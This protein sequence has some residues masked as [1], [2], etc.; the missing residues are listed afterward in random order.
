MGKRQTRPA[1]FDALE[2]ANENHILGPGIFGLVGFG[3]MI[4]DM[5]TTENL[6]ACFGIDEIIQ[7][8]Q[9]TAI[10]YRTWNHIP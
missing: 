6:S 8:D 9:Q 7:G 5:S 1:T 10:G 2:Q 3:G 4:E